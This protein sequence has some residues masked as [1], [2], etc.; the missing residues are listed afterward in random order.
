MKKT[1]AIPRGIRNHNPGNIEQKPG[2]R[3]QGEKESQQADPRFVT[4][5]SPKWG[6][7]AIARILITYQDARQ[8]KDGSR[9]DTVREIINRWAP[10]TENDTESYIANVSRLSKIGENTRLDV[11]QFAVMKALVKAIITHENG[12][13][14]YP[15]ATIDAGLRLAGIEPPKK[16]ITR[17]ADVIATASAGGLTLVTAALQEGRLAISEA[18]QTTQEVT[19]FWPSKGPW[20]LTAIIVLLLLIT[21]FKQFRDHQTGARP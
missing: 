16:A 21:L 17:Q 19:A 14:P 8:A 3:W 7:R 15:S 5:E 20:I 1:H 11:Y 4:F 13:N 2:V 12:S 18:L 6:I 9:I 10:A